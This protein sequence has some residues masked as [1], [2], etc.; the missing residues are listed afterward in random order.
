MHALFSH[1]KVESPSFQT[2]YFTPE[3]PL[4]FIPGQFIELSIPHNNPD[5]RGSKRWFTIATSPTNSHIGITTRIVQDASSFKQ[6]LQALKPGE[7]VDITMPMGD[8]VLPKDMN[9][10]LIFVAGGI[11]VTPFRS[12][13]EWIA[14]HDEERDIHLIHAIS[15]EDD[16]VF[17][18]TFADA[19]IPV[20][21]IVSHP[22]DSWSGRRGFLTKDHIL[23]LTKP[24]KDAMIYVAGPEP[25]VELDA[26]RASTL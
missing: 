12:M 24:N 6:S 13:A 22:S 18:K 15:T 21:H 4:S 3:S 2:F 14:H 17:Q 16:I 11:G 25:L 8:F 1:H 10:P 9:A 19:N 20:T 26:L 5:N 7:K 23:K